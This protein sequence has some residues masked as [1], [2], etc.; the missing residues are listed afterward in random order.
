MHIKTF[1]SYSDRLPPRSAQ[2]FIFAVVIIVLAAGVREFFSLLGATL[3]FASFYPAVLVIAL[4][5][6]PWAGAFGAVLAILVAWWAFVPPLFE[7]NQLGIAEYANLVLFLLSALLVVWLAHLYRQQIANLQKSEMERELLLKE[8]HHRVRNSFAVVQSIVRATLADQP[9]RAEKIVGRVQAVSRTNDIIDQADKHQA[10]LRTLI[11]NELEP[12]QA[13][14]RIHLVGPDLQ[15]SS[16]VARNVCLVL[17]EMTTNAVKHGSLKEPN[18]RVD[19]SWVSGGDHCILT[20]QERDGPIITDSE[21]RGF[22]TRMMTRSLD[23]IEG[24]IAHEF[25][26]TG[27]CSR[28]SFR[29]Q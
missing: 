21:K 10:S 1:L 14:G 20:W 8:M 6:G 28:I 29:L 18:G 3:L 16:D 12:Y 24:S 9:E 27:I 7:F 4:F 25:A 22:G 15:L 19:V 11:L 2:A 5:A 17:H 23:A 26:P 13:G